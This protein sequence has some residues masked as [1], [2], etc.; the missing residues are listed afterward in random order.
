MLTRTIIAATA[1]LLLARQS[2]AQQGYE[3]EVYNTSISAP[4]A[5]E[6]ELHSNFVPSGSQLFDDADGRAT[7][8]AFRSAI[9]VST[10]LTSWLE[11]SVYAI[12]YAR[13]GAGVQYVGNRA[14]LTAVVPRAWNLPFG[15]GVSQELGYARP[16]F[17]ENRWAYEITPILGRE[18]RRVSLVLNPAFERGIGNNSEGEWEFEPRAE[19]GYA[20]GPDESIGLEYYSILGPV[21]G[22]DAR[23]HQR[24]QRLPRPPGNPLSRAPCDRSRGRRQVRCSVRWRHRRLRRQRNRRAVRDLSARWNYYRGAASSARHR[25]QGCLAGNSGSRELLR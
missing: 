3:F 22:F 7:H 25:N 8:R 13:N 4:G 23:N 19:L 9:E 2:Q 11:G 20:L 16:G 10:G 18:L 24:H 21:E 14:R 17:S 12:G 1:L 5:G 15:L 6:L